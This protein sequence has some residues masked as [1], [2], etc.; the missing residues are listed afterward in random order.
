VFPE[1][2]KRFPGNFI[3]MQKTER[4]LGLPGIALSGSIDQYLEKGTEK[5]PQKCMI[6]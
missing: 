4:N 2:S 6:C 5:L 1:D 3:T